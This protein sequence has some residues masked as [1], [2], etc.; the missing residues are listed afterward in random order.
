MKLYPKLA[1]LLMMPLLF[2][3]C[4]EAEE[5]GKLHVSGS[6]EL[7]KPADQVQLDVGVVSQAATARQALSSNSEAMRKV[8]AA[9]KGAG[10]TEGEY[11]TGRFS[12]NP[13]HSQRP[14]GT[15][16]WA[17]KIAAYS[18][19]N[20]IHIESKQIEIV[21]KIIDEANSAGANSIGSISF[22]LSDAQPFRK[23]A[24]E[25][26]TRR[27]IE[28]AT[29]LAASAGIKLG[30]IVAIE[31]DAA[32]ISPPEPVMYRNMAMAESASPPITAGD[33]PVSATVTV[34]YE[35]LQ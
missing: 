35:I 9:I 5:P 2:N 3:F 23:E 17:P 15:R 20:S 34:S 31:L 25:K 24:I 12:L 19:S 8:V 28:N 16:E 30:K 6:A 4:L 22:S 21:G 1:V 26:A 29:N 32:Q 10:L 27:A 18:V 14:Q 13:I 7:Q 33:V 11:R